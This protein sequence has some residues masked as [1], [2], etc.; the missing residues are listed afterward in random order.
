MLNCGKTQ[1]DTILKNELILS[2]YQSSTPGNRVHTSKAPRA[3]E[4]AKINE[5]LY[6]LATSENIFPIGPQLVEKAKQMDS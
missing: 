2:L 1:I 4:Y 5:A 3:S 6:D